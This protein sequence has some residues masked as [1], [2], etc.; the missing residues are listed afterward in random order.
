MATLGDLGV[1]GMGGEFL[2]PHQKNKWRLTFNG[3]GRMVN[4]EALTLQAVTCDL[5]KI[6]FE[7]IQL[8]RYNSRGYIPGKYTWEPVNV[9]FEADI[10]G[11]VEAAIRN[12]LEIQQ[13]IIGMQ[14]A[15][16]LPTASSGSQLKFSVTQELLDGDMANTLTAWYL[17]GAWLL[18]VDWG[19]LDY[20]SG[21]TLKITCT[22]RFDHA[23]TD[24]IGNDGLAVGG[25]A[26][27][28]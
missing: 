19:D 12:Q 16:R 18:N 24:I 2:Q 8:D 21:E 3:L 13:R 26:P 20:A 15:P 6:A 28:L 7:D 25:F 23:R 17:E 4:S 22:I 1:I 10:G 11:R 27:V 9:T 5:P 14:S